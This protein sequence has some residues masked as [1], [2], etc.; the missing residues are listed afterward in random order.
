MVVPH[1]RVD[2]PV[3]GVHL[4]LAGGQL[5]L[6]LLQLEGGDAELLGGEVQLG[7]QLARL[8]HQL[9]HLVLGL[10]RPQLHASM[11]VVKSENVKKDPHPGSLALLLAD[12]DPVAG[13]VLLHLEG[14]D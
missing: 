1:A 7:L 10:G 2:R 6:L 12:I 8:G 9:V 13:V 5:L 4:E 14:L 11:I 3:Q